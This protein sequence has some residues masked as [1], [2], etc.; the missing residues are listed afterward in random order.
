[1]VEERVVVVARLKARAGREERLKETLL[2]LV[3][4]TRREEGAVRY[5]LHE[6]L[7]N[8]GEYMF[9]EIWRTRKDLEVHMTT[10]HF[11]GFM[12]KAKD[13]LSEPGDVTLWRKVG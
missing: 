8:P 1:M 12:E 6:S 4:P 2:E 13:L 5:E 9:F 10:P 11:R 3:A 7:E